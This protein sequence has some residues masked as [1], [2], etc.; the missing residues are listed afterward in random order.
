MLKGR[1]RRKSK[2]QTLRNFRRL[3]MHHL[4][5][6]CSHAILGCQ[7]ATSYWILHRSAELPDDIMSGLLPYLSTMILSESVCGYSALKCY[8]TK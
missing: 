1:I 2:I 7:T 3:S 8:N 4:L 6:F 5:V